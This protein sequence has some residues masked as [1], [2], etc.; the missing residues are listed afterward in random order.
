MVI[1]MFGLKI[2]D[3]YETG[4]TYF[5]DVTDKLGR[6]LYTTDIIEY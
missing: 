5:V 6:S 2:D 3:I 1:F 4:H